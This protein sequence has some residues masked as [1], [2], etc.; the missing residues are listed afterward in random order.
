M[1]VAIAAGRISAMALAIVLAFAIGICV[2]AQTVSARQA[3][4]NQQALKQACM[5]DYQS[6]CAGT[7]PGGGRIKACLEQN[8]ARLSPGCRGALQNLNAPQ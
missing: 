3:S 6:L 7:F 1:D 5:D 8:M 2:G 4:P